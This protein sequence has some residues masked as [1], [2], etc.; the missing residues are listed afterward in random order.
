MNILYIIGLSVGLGVPF[1]V[2]LAWVIMG[3][4]MEDE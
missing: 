2:G 1:L 3:D 4:S